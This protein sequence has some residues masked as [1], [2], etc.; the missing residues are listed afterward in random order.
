[1]DVETEP[2]TVVTL[3]KQIGSVM[4]ASELDQNVVKNDLMQAGFRSDGAV[5]VFYGLK[6]VATLTLLGAALLLQ[7]KM[8][9]NPVLRLV[10]MISGAGAGWVMPG[11]FLEKRI[12]KRQERIRL[13]LP[14]G[15]DLLVVSVE[16]GLGL[17]QAIQHVARELQLSHPTLS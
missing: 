16:A 2:S 6:I 13:S 8:P 12:K 10:L 9:D 17:D 11:F 7:S 3:L 5:P 1:A 14:D 15:L 4:R